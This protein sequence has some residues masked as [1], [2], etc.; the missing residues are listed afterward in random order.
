MG[1]QYD[2]LSD[3]DKVFIQKQKLFFIA[4]SSVAETNLSPRGYECL[5]IHDAS[6]LYMLDLP[7]SGNRTARDSEENGEFTLLF[8]A[9]EGEAHLLR[10]FC[11]ATLISKENGVFSSL[12]QKFNFSQNYVRQI[13]EFKVYKVETSCGMSVPFMPYKRQRDELKDWAEKMADS[14]K[15]DQIGRAHV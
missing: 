2:K 3:K 11:K 7:G 4:S 10:L 8:T 12:M 14:G 5:Y 1:K 9:F 13:F 15:L 6:T